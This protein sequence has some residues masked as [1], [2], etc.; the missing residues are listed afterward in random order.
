MP[1]AMIGLHLGQR[2]IPRARAAGRWLIT[3]AA[4][5]LSTYALD[6]VATG[7]G[8]VLAA[9][10]LF[11]GV[12]RTG[13]LT[14]L[15]ASYVAW[16]AGMWTN[17]QA[18]WEL[19]ERTGT[20]TNVLSKAAYDV[21][22]RA[23]AKPRWR[24]MATD[25]GYAGTELAKETPYYAGAVGTALLSDAV[26][27]VDAIVFLGGANLGAALYEIALGQGVRLFLRRRPAAYASFDTAWC[28]RAYLAEYYSRIE[29]D[30]RHAIAF[31]A[32]AFA[33]MP[34]GQRVLVYGAGP[35]LHHVFLA[36][37]KASEIHLADYLPGN[38]AEIRRWLSRDPAAHDWR[39]FVAYTLQCEGIGAPSGEQIAAREELARR[40]VTRL[41]AADLRTFPILDPIGSGPYDVVLSA[42]CADSATSDR[43]EWRRF[44]L[45][46]GALARSGGW[47]LTAALRRTRGYLVG[48]G[49]FPSADLDD[50]D[51]AAVLRAQVPDGDMP[52]GEITVL[53][54]DLE[55]VH[56]KGYSGVL[57]GKCRRRPSCK[58]R[59]ALAA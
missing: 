41:L 38:L 14:F 31:F 9:S 59:D 18:N 26:S 5:V 20:S 12:G 29:A 45:Q 34:P 43:A 10:G 13:G 39:P 53:S 48:G 3:L 46:I 57:L 8:L 30:E 35:T 28:P 36:A 21:L 40:K 33:A 19:L 7:A 37:A 47:L 51:L 17:L 54:V 4:T 6:A 52:D 11:D 58:R 44:M 49:L 22:R 25:L 32:A 42:F 1:A 55:E 24:R 27:A 56:A 2:R 50:G 16:G 15:L 23:G